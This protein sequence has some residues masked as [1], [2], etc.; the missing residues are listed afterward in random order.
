[1]GSRRHTPFIPRD[2]ASTEGTEKRR[3]DAG[4]SERVSSFLGDAINRHEPIMKIGSCRV[5]GLDC[6]A[7]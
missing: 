7:A 4:V 1:M 5:H 2:A 6:V 3:I